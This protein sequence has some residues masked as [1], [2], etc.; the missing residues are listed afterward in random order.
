LSCYP[1]ESD[2]GLIVGEKIGLLAD[3][4]A[5][6][7]SIAVRDTREVNVGI[8]ISS[9]QINYCGTTE[10]NIPTIFLR[11]SKVAF[12]ITLSNTRFTLTMSKKMPKIL[13][14]ALRKEPAITLPKFL[15][16]NLLIDLE[17]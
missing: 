17:H 10:T 16:S 13:R 15:Q 11:S 2:A 9:G 12:V 6:P 14:K 3:S 8:S 4:L 1:V 5:L 7:C